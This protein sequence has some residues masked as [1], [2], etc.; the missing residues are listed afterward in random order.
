MET[1][2]A[3]HHFAATAY[4]GTNAVLSVEHDLQFG[5]LNVRFEFNARGDIRSKQIEYVVIERYT[6]ENEVDTR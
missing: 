4:D 1:D 6:I 2:D 5:N 3:F